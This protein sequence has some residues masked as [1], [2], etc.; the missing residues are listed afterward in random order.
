MALR[1]IAALALAAQAAAAFAWTRVEGGSDALA[2]AVAGAGDDEIELVVTDRKPDLAKVARAAEGK[3]LR[4]DLSACS[5]LTDVPARAFR[6]N[7][8][9]ES[10]VLPEGLLRIGAGAFDGSGLRAAAL[11]STVE[12]IGDFAFYRTPLESVTIPR[13]TEKV[14]VG[15]FGACRQLPAIEVEEGNQSYASVDRTLMSRDE[16]RLIQYPAGRKGAFSVPESVTEIGAGAFEGA[17]KLTAVVLPPDLLT[18]GGF[19]FGGCTSLDELTIPDAVTRIGQDALGGTAVRRVFVPESVRSLGEK[20]FE[21]ALSLESVTVDG[22]NEGY[23]SEGGVLFTS[24]GTLVRYP[25][26]RGGSEY[27]APKGTKAVAAFAFADAGSLE[28]VTLPEGTERVGKY[29]FRNCSSLAKAGIPKS[30][31]EIGREAFWGTEVKRTGPLPSWYR[32]RRGG[33][34]PRKAKQKTKPADAADAK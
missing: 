8:G 34:A 19:A 27:A 2:E 6:G 17:E 7:E 14:G 10:V 28:S 20:P 30:T 9:L 4:L 23:R 18:I 33:T 3:R 13:A 21:G 11:P 1:N 22:G 15:A 32:S 26:A 31:T 24:D 12:E 5:R 29:A 25:P 16:Q